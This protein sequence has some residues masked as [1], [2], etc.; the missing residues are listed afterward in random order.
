MVRKLGPERTAGMA[1]SNHLK[2]LADPDEMVGAVLYM[3]SDA[4]SFMTGQCLTVDGGM[5]PAR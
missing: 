5:V 4:A 3:A 2:R 1:R